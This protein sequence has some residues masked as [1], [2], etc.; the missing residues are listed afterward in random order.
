M[1]VE[2]NTP[3]ASPKKKPTTTLQYLFDLDSKS[4]GNGHF[5]NSGKQSSLD[6][7][8]EELLSIIT[9]CTFVFTFTDPSESPSQQDLKRLKLTQLL[10]LVKSTK[11]PL[12]DQFCHLWL[13]CYLPT[14]FAPS[15][16]L[17]MPL[18]SLTYL[19]RKTPLLLLHLLGHTCKLAACG[20]GDLL[21]IWGSIINGFTIPLKE[22]HKLFLMRVLIPLHKPKGLQVYHRQLAYCVSQFV[23]KEPVL[24]GIVVRGILKYWPITNCQKQVLLVGELEELVEIIDPEQY[25]K[26]ALPLF[27][28]IT[29][30]LNSWNSQVAERALYVLNNEQFRKMA[31]EAMD[32]VFPVIVEGMEKNLKWHW[33]KSVR[34]LT[35]TVKV[36][37]EEME[38]CLYSKCVINLEL[39][40]SAA[41]QEEI[42]RREK[43]KGLNGLLMLLLLPRI[44]SSNHHIVYVFQ[45]K[46]KAQ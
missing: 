43:W 45:L 4:N 9:Y 46:N 23:Q 25:R 40:E 2:R 6:S 5:S 42:K 15:L 17:P 28:Q 12:H 34:Q 7:E 33:S 38:P 19:M 22:E 39:R 13:P 44:S 14:S 18:S 37:L 1:G 30:C 21:E 11:K 27:T 36:M 8:N 26:L 31:Q 32:E 41:Q 24:G 35:Q 16:H 10:S 3:K 20:I 29:R